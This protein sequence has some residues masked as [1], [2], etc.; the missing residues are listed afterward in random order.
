M[1]VDC[2][3]WEAGPI[4]SNYSTMIVTMTTGDSQFL[5]CNVHEFADVTDIGPVDGIHERRRNVT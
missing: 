5:K 3:M 1:G 4:L 2:D